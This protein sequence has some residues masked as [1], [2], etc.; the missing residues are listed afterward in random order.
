MRAKATKRTRRAA[1]GLACAI[2][3]AGVGL[4]AARDALQVGLRPDPALTVPYAWPA[5]LQLDAPV[6]LAH[7]N[8]YPAFARVGM[9]GTAHWRGEALMVQV[10]EVT[11]AAQRNVG[12]DCLAL[13]AFRVGLTPQ[14][15]FGPD[16]SVENPPGTWSAWQPLSAARTGPRSYGEQGMWELVIATPPQSRPWEQRLAIE[17][18]CKVKD[19]SSFQLMAFTQAWFLAHAAHTQA[20]AP[21]PCAHSM[22]L[23]DALAARCPGAVNARLASPWGRRE[24]EHPPHPEAS[25][26]DIAVAEG[27]P[28]SI[29]PLVRAGV[30]VN[31]TSGDS[32]DTA[33]IYA[34]GNGDA[35]SVRELLMLGARRDQKNGIGFS[36]YNAASVSGFGDLAMELAEQGVQRDTNTGAAYTALSLAAYNGDTLTVRRLLE[37]GSDPDTQVNGWYNALHH[38]VKKDNLE[39]A[40]TML[41]GGAN[42]NVGVTARRGETPLMMAA[43][44]GNIPM[45][46]LLVQMGAR[47]NSIDAM[48][49]NATDYAEYFHKPAASDYLCRLGQRAT[50]GERTAVCPDRVNPDSVGFGVK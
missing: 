1:F 12:F 44:N 24:L 7:I 5:S 18:K 42:P 2:G 25:W 35:H 29:R 38:A 15:F 48:G 10:S 4:Y 40:R 36:A 37:S 33:L 46:Q 32:A 6:E 19:G 28:E 34:A 8:N 41:A 3:L 27:L 45:M 31:T 13:Q 49:K 21:D 17:V 47:A 26:L 9:R 20:R 39:L 23:R 11:H 14:G 30:D 50:T 16:Y 43:E 22:R